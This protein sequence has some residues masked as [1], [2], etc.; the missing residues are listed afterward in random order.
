MRTTLTAVRA[1]LAGDRLPSPAAGAR[2]LRLGALPEIC[3][4]R[5]GRAG[6][7]LDTACRRV[8]GRV[9]TVSVDAVAPG[10]GTVVVREGEA[11]G[12]AGRRRGSRACRSPWPPTRRHHGGWRRGGWRPTR[13]ASGGFPRMLG[14]R[15][16]WGRLRAVVDA[17]QKRVPVLP[18]AAEEL[19]R[20]ATLLGT[21]DEAEHVIGAWLD[22]GADRVTSSCRRIDPKRSSPPSSMSPAASPPRR[23]PPDDD[24]RHRHLSRTQTS[25]AVPKTALTLPPERCCVLC[26]IHGN[27]QQPAG[28]ARSCAS[29]RATRV[30]DHPVPRRTPSANHLPAAALSHSARG[31]AASDPGGRDARDDVDDAGQPALLD[32]VPVL[33]LAEA[34]DAVAT[35]RVQAAVQ[36][37]MRQEDER[38]DVGQLLSAERRLAGRAAT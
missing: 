26:R 11:A 3:A 25:R 18:G 29:A 36:F 17:A 20:E 31:A 35:A 24:S 15:L 34:G 12:T 4:G 10:G 38:G 32:R 28:A 22:A 23:P 7:G 8:G 14:E 9:D 37:G 5:I 2:P 27:T 30:P 19:A 21:Y 6:T 33:V 16:V 1:L 13:R